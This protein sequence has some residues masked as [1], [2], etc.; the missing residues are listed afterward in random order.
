MTCA[1]FEAA[2]KDTNSDASNIRL[3]ELITA[4]DYSGTGLPYV[5]EEYLH[6]FC[7]STSDYVRRR[8]IG[9]ALARMLGVSP[10]VAEHLQVEKRR[11]QALGE[12][13][14]SPSGREETK[15]IAGVIMRQALED[16]IEFASFWASDKVRNSAP[17]FPK[18]SG[19]HWIK[20][21]QGFLD[22]LS[23]LALANPTTDASILYPVSVL[24][25]DSF[26]WASSSDG[27]PIA[28]VQEGSLTVLLSEDFEHDIQVLD[29]PLA[30]IESMKTRPS[31][32][33]YDSQSRQ[34]EHEPWD[35]ILAL[36]HAHWTYR[37]NTSTRAATEITILFMRPQDAQEC[38]SA[39]KELRQVN[40]TSIQP[41]KPH[42]RMSR[43]PVIDVSSSPPPVSNEP[44]MQDQQAQVVEA[45][46]PSTTH[47][48]QRSV[49]HSSPKVH[50][51]SSSDQLGHSPNDKAHAPHQ[52]PDDAPAA[53]SR[54]QARLAP[55]L[56]Q[57]QG[58]QQP[59]VPVPGRDE[60]K[61]TQKANRGDEAHRER[62]SST[63]QDSDHTEG[64]RKKKR[65]KQAQ[66]QTHGTPSTAMTTRSSV[67]STQPSKPAEAANSTT[68]PTESPAPERTLSKR[69]TY[70]KGKLPKVS[71]AAKQRASQQVHKRSDIFDLP[72]ADRSKTS[73]KW[74][75]TSELVSE[76]D[77]VA[78][79]HTRESRVATR[80]SPS[81]SQGR[82]TRSKKKAEDDDEFLPVTAKAAKKAGT[83]RKPVPNSTVPGNPPKKKAKT[84]RDGT[85][86]DVSTS[87][88]TSSNKTEARR[89]EDAV[90]EESKE[91]PT[92][93]GSKSKASENPPSSI[94]ASRTSLIGGLLGLQRQAQPSKAAFKKPALPSR[95]LHR[96]STPTRRQL[97]PAM[98]VRGPRT[99]TPRRKAL[100][101]PVPLISSS[102]PLYP[103]AEE[104]FASAQHGTAEQ[105][106]L[107]SNSKP[108]PA[109]PHAESTAISGHADRDDVDL[110]KQKGDLQVERSDPFK[111]RPVHHAATSFTRR[112]TG[113]DL[114]EKPAEIDDL[115][116]SDTEE[117]LV[118]AASQPLPR[119]KRDHGRKLSVTQV[120]KSVSQPLAETSTLK[121]VGRAE[122]RRV[123]VSRPTDQQDGEQ[124]GRASHTTERKSAVELRRDDI[125]LS[126][127]PTVGSGYEV[128]LE[129]TATEAAKMAPMQINEKPDTPVDDSIL[130]APPQHIDDTQ[131][132]D[133]TDAQNHF[134]ADGDTTLVD[135]DLEDQLPT[136]QKISTPT[137]FRST[138]PGSGSPSS[139][140]ST[141]AEAEP[142]SPPPIPTADAEEMEWE[143]S[144][145]P[146]Q[147]ALHDLLIRVSKR[148]T[149][150]V[151]D[152]ETAVTDIAE[153]YAND[154]EHLLNSLLERH[155]G[156]YE[157][158]WE[159][160]ETKKARL[161]REMEVSVR[162]LD[163]ERKR[164][165]ALT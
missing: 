74:R 165:I 105:E 44:A 35:L 113:D 141:S 45:A 134:N 116:S 62:N 16:G 22:D 39:I 142:P 12:I 31:A 92:S 78:P 154:G 24:A 41:S 65:A 70:S 86:E 117:L 9:I 98:P 151:V 64:R 53:G 97:Q 2:L 107:S 8:W 15:I 49:H 162:A 120:S 150:H 67:H 122:A 94:A 51:E 7:N 90:A 25:S 153:V 157:G 115:F 146:H 137:H 58:K 95:A 133:A 159:D 111:Q 164:V 160:M 21:F 36:K 108:T 144:L 102:P 46:K 118:K 59:T 161:R 126:K 109:S 33:L 13:L 26:R 128:D 140:S 143:G 87:R 19:P 30:H 57:P 3:H 5:A 6:A 40:K 75:P 28:I 55:D 145:Q 152:N 104:G 43:S 129:H 27:V 149:R 158:M 52:A 1:A 4:G 56:A 91:R 50:I 32:S 72:E 66:S 147:R 54:S 29:V 73:T 18:E 119:S 112:L 127:E 37:L 96:P 60:F 69:E 121:I 131:V 17:N 79:A 10:E 48:G 23:A 61:M 103:V 89:V 14:V 110:E 38:E 93:R 68:S 20:Q 84:E 47:Q 124:L 163:K 101:A 138:P 42:P 11:L 155:N 82:K 80:V 156:A 148:V 76:A 81:I 85:A 106:A 99:P 83:K 132:E 125:G 123:E 139:H 114:S 71:K 88:A 130:A 136:H 135:E 77:S 34:T 63:L 100:D